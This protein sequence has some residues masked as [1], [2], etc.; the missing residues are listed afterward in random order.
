MY[1]LTHVYNNNMC[2]ARVRVYLYA[3][4]TYMIYCYTSIYISLDQLICG[5]YTYRI[6]NIPI[7]CRLWNTHDNNNMFMST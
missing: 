5:S 4:Y 6:F 1:S 2:K 3:V 7:C